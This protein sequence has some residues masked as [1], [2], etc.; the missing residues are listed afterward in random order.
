LEDRFG[1]LPTET[2]ELLLTMRLRW[3]AR[4]LGMEKV[5]LKAGKLIAA[6]VSEEKSPYFQGP[7]FA[8]VLN[9]LKE[10]SR[11]ASMYQRNGALRL[12]IENI[13]SIRVMLG[14]FEDMAGMTAAEAAEMTSGRKAAEQE[15]NK[16]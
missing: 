14:V 7:M 2:E 3:V 15:G 10:N 12:R 9:Y 4:I 1:P 6:F 5:I 13:N 11:D 8:R 16:K